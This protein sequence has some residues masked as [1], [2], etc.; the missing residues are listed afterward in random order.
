MPQTLSA[1]Q[2]CTNALGMLGED[3]IIALTDTS[4]RAIWCNSFFPSARDA[5][6]EQMK[7]N[8]A[9]K[10]RTL[11]QISPAPTIKWDYGYTLPADYITMV[12]IIPALKDYEI[13]DQTLYTDEAAVD[14]I[15]IFRDTDT[16]HWSPLFT[17]YMTYKLAALLAN[18]LKADLEHAQLLDR[19]AE[20]I[21]VK[22]QILDAQEE[23]TKALT[24]DDLI[25]VRN[26]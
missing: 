3:S 16:T 4:S 21:R 18:P 17:E 13:I 14:I 15:Y 26:V 11:A 24:A 12:E 19:K 23:S 10:I 2:I 1:V 22:A 8:F 9:K 25:T 6:L 20:M 7:P 5:S